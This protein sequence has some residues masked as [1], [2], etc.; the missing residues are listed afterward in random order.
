MVAETA[1]ERIS[2]LL[3]L[4]AANAEA[5]AKLEQQLA[6]DEQ[7][8]DEILEHA[9][10]SRTP[11]V[12]H[13]AVQILLRACGQRTPSSNYFSS[14]AEAKDIRLQ[15]VAGSM[16]V[17][18]VQLGKEADAL[19]ARWRDCVRLESLKDLETHVHVARW[20]ITSP[21]ERMCP[22]E[23]RIV[24]AYEDFQRAFPERFN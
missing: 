12:H 6:A 7:A 11:R 4:R 5:I 3:R 13:V 20:C 8:M 16:G 24:K 18:L 21:L 1:A 23:C 22:W 2:A 15:Q 10:L 14:L 9:A 17:E 19:L